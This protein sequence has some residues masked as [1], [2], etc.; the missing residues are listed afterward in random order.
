M[1]CMVLNDGVPDK[2]CKTIE[3]LWR[4]MLKV[5]CLITASFYHGIYSLYQKVADRLIHLQ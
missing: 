2:E 1:I 4:L 3:L 5:Y